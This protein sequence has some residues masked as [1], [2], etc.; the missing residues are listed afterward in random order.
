MPRMKFAV[1]TIV[2]SVAASAAPMVSGP[3]VYDGQLVSGANL[4]NNG[5]YS[6]PATNLVAHL[7]FEGYYAGAPAVN[8][9]GAGACT[10]L[11]VLTTPLPQ[12]TYQVFLLHLDVSPD[13]LLNPA[14]LAQ[15]ASYGITFDGA[16]AG[17]IVTRAQLNNTDATL[18]VSG[19]TYPTALVQARG[20]DL[21]PFD[22]VTVDAS[23]HALLR[24]INLSITSGVDEIRILVENP[25]PST[26][27]LL[28]SALPLLALGRRR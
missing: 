1:A 12:A 5:P 22:S 4:T 9:V 23:N 2:L 15:D 26:W 17:L 8:C 11:N 20:L 16:I 7:F 28:G 24:A 19:A 25:E 10:V 21:L 3:Y 6:S 13:R 27:L 18:G 14:V